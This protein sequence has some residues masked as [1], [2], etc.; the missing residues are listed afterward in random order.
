MGLIGGS[1]GRA[2]SLPWLAAVVA[3]M[4]VGCG[5]SGT[6]PSS[7]SEAN[8]DLT[9]PREERSATNSSAN[10]A[11]AARARAA[12]TKIYA[13]LE[14]PGD[15]SADTLCSVMSRDARRETRQYVNQTVRRG[16][17]YTCEEAIGVLVD[18]SKGTKG[19][20]GVADARVVA[21]NVEG[22]RATAT[23]QF[24]KGGDEKPIGLVKEDGAWKLAALPAEGDE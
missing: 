15:I 24:G 6:T 17:R 5:D 1:K 3:S 23:V 20:R 12:V 2:G 13:G 14:R 4:A 10:K 16:T 22:D 19:F 8:N 18:R 11:Q 21:V 9:A 7:A